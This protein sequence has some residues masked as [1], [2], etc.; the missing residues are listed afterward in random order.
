MVRE[1]LG[2]KLAKR[3]GFRTARH[4]AGV[5]DL[6][7]YLREANNLSLEWC[8][9]TRDQVLDRAFWETPWWRGSE[10]IKAKI[11]LATDQA[12]AGFVFREEL[13]YWLGDGRERIVVLRCTPFGTHRG[14]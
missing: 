13:P 4:F 8:G 10:D 2:A 3:N 6:Q 7:G 9:Y 11:R 12:A 14:R 5:M 1:G